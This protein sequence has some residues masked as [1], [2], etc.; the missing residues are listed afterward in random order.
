MPDNNQH[1]YIEKGCWQTT[2]LSSGAVISLYRN[3]S[4]KDLRII[5]RPDGPHQASLVRASEMKQLLVTG[6]AKNQSE[7]A[8]IM[9]LSRARVSQ[10]LRQLMANR[11]GGPNLDEG[12][13][14]GAR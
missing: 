2:K 8:K 11:T 4:T 12:S 7:V 9:G 6:K 10:I 1:F 14:G 3:T 13:T 5:R